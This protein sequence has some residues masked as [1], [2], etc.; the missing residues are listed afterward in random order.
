M[1]QVK[2]LKNNV[3]ALE[4][5]INEELRRIGSTPGYKVD[6]RDIKLLE[7]GGAGMMVAMIIYNRSRVK[8]IPGEVPGATNQ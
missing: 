3:A 5:D 4:R 8:A 1:I 6:L 7:A 2:I